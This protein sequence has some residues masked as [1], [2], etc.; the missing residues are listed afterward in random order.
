VKGQENQESS[1]IR[2]ADDHEQLQVR[3]SVS[4]GLGFQ[5]MTKHETESV[6][7]GT[8][9]VFRFLLHVASVPGLQTPAFNPLPAGNQ[10]APGIRPKLPTI[11]KLYESP[12]S[13]HRM[14]SW[15]PA[16]YNWD[17]E[18]QEAK[19][20]VTVVALKHF[21]HLVAEAPLGQTTQYMRTLHYL[22]DSLSPEQRW[23]VPQRTD[24]KNDVVLHYIFCCEN[25]RSTAWSLKRRL[26]YMA[27]DQ[28]LAA[29]SDGLIVSLCKSC[30]CTNRTTV[31]AT[32][33]SYC[34]QPETKQL[35]EALH[36][37]LARSLVALLCVIARAQDLEPFV[38]SLLAVM[39]RHP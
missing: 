29:V 7:P 1:V 36:I 23:H 22:R 31:D 2:P 11:F 5:L 32:Y 37:P 17:Q 8:E 24:S 30:A 39:A 28:A 4:L 9:S 33:E 25:V 16:N 3:S 27:N 19:I 12:V 21:R 15:D 20:K 14:D 35:E 10:D 6:L 38:A 18:N 13:D 26:R 34:Q